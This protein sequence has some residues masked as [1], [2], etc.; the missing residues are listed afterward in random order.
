MPQRLDSTHWKRRLPT[1][2]M[3]SAHGDR[4]ELSEAGG[5]LRAR[6]GVERGE[7]RTLY[8]NQ[9]NYNESNPTRREDIERPPEH[10]DQFFLDSD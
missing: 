10:I 1:V 8:A 3:L 4:R 6:V 7:L 2:A 5:L 9:T